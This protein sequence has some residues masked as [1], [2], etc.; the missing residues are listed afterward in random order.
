MAVMPN[1]ALEPILYMYPPPTKML[2]TLKR[3]PV[4]AQFPFNVS[5]AA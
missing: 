4:P 1:P 3:D 2:L 5:V